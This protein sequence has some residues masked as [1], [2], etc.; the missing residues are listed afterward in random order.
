MDVGNQTD[1]SCFLSL[2]HSHEGYGTTQKP[3]KHAVTKHKVRKLNRTWI[4]YK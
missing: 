1:T 3:S 2:S 4:L